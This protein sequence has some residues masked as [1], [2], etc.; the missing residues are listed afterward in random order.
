MNKKV[1]SLLLIGGI[2]LL[3][4]LLS[5]DFFLRFDLTQDKSY[6]LSQATKDI[7]NELEEPVTV[8]A[9]FTK[10]LPQQYNKSLS[11]FENLLREYA[12]RSGGMV[13]FE[14]I[15]PNESPEK[16]QEAAQNGIQ[17]LLINAREKDQVVQKRAFMGAV[18]SQGDQQDIIPFVS[19]QGPLEYSLTTSIKK[20]S[21]AAKPTIGIV[22]GN[23]EPGFD[24]IAQVYQAL[25]ILYD[26]ESVN[27]SDPV[28]QRHKAV[29]LLNPKDSIGQIGLLNLNNYLD[30]GGNLAVAINTVEGDFQTM[31]GSTIEN[32]ITSWLGSKGVDV[33]SSFILDA[34]CAT[35]TAQQRKGFFMVNTQI[36]FPYYPRVTSFG[37][38]PVV[39]GLD[40][41][42]FPFVSPITMS[43]DSSLN[44]IP[45][46]TTS[47]RSAIKNVPLFL[48]VQKQWTSAD[49][50][51]GPQTIG[52]VVEGDFGNT[53]VNSKMI[54]FGDGDF[55]ISE[56]RGQGNADNFSL[57]VNAID[58]LSDDTGLISLRT[59][60]VSS[61]PIDDFEEAKATT[62]KWINF[63][64]PLVLVILIGLFRNQRNRQLR[65]KRMNES[66]L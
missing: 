44:F 21:V 66:Y 27:L 42:S 49:F 17:P 36:E 41:I 50:P 51:V 46:L 62:L 56:G 14:F 20:V 4:N 19:P 35:V 7:L 11:D 16:E 47:E 38:H 22:Q 8:T 10:D 64:L 25:S 6:T 30:N 61:R 53:G 12:T 60:G 55:P 3:L 1:I 63:L 59:K 15:N 5:R 2:L 29:L 57:L 39:G 54:V 23:G 18:I 40:Q 52:A 33:G 13:N 65:N 37:E 32:D 28:P 24:Q 31:Q 26:I 34:N 43:G 48:E 45:I 58:W 9:Y